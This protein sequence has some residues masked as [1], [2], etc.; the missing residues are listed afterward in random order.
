[1]GFDNPALIDSKLMVNN[2]MPIIKILVKAN[3]HHGML[4]LY[5]KLMSH[6]S[7]INQAIGLPI[8]IPRSTNFKKSRVIKEV[9]VNTDAPNIF[10]TP[11]SLVLC[12]AVNMTSPNNPKQEINMANIEKYFVSV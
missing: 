3:A 1:M 4:I 8:K 10:R 7:I 5:S 11:I 2:A 12:S 6:L 9:I